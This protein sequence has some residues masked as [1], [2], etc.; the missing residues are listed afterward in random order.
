VNGS[1]LPFGALFIFCFA[2]TVIDLIWRLNHRFVMGDARRREKEAPRRWQATEARHLRAPG[3]PDCGPGSLDP[4][5][6]SGERRACANC[7]RV[8]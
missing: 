4:D 3:C 7:D 5:G 1:A 8:F 6:K 2:Y